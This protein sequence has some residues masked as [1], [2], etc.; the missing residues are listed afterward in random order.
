MLPIKSAAALVAITLSAAVFAQGIGEN[1]PY[2]CTP[3]CQAIKAVAAHQ[4]IDVIGQALAL[5][6]ADNGN[7]PTERQGLAAL[8]SEPHPYLER[9]PRDPWGHPYQYRNPGEH[10]PV[11]VFSFGSQASGIVGSWQ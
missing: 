2:G 11:D 5:Y 8:A 1:S 4:D 6:K 10:G 3:R 9:L 7:Y